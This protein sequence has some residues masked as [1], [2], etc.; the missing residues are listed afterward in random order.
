[1]WDVVVRAMEEWGCRCRQRD[2]GWLSPETVDADEEL[3]S[4]IWTMADR[5][6]VMRR[7]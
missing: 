5:A 7:L 1:M 4:R 3:A 2:G 6:N